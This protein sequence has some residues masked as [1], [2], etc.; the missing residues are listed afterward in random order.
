[1]L[2]FLNPAKEVSG[3]PSSS[4][5]LREEEREKKMEVTAQKMKKANLFIHSDALTEILSRVPAKELLT[6]KL[7]CKEWH[8]VITSRSFAKTQLGTTEVVLTGFILQEKFKWCNDDIKIVSYIFVEKMARGGSKVNLTVFDFLPEDVVMLA[9]CKGL[10]C[11]RSCFP[12][13][14]P[15]IYV[16]NPWRREWVKLE[17]PWLTSKY[18]ISNSQRNTA[19]ALALDFDP[20]KGFVETF[21]LVRVKQVEVERDEDDDEQEGKLYFTFEL[22]SSEIGAWW[23]SNETCQCYSKW[24][25]NEGIYI[26]GV[27]HWLNGYGVL[28]FDVENELSWLVPAPVPVS[29]FMAVPEVCIGESEGRL[30]Y[31]VV[32]EQG[33]HVW[34]L[35]DCY[36]YRWILMYCKSLEEIEGEWPQ[37]FINL[38]EHMLERVNGPWV[39]PLAFKDG[40]LLMKCV[41]LYLFDVKNNKMA[42]A[43][44]LQ[45]LKSQCMFKP[46]VLA[47]SLSL[48][49]FN[50]V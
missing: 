15:F 25:N 6:L 46:T 1:M 48:V 49:P 26:G 14:K 28:T 3:R 33:V 27:L 42:Q 35:E 7:V 39:K 5:A 47:H 23:K 36:E 4:L 22:Y 31:V 24:V 20:S 37:S 2:N 8:R 11:C 9:S 12:S 41:Y 17:W 16:C 38:K 50:T 29:E 13:E 19:L 43:C 34:C 30:H 21:K 44:S 18:E 32:S 10:V 45:D 40:L